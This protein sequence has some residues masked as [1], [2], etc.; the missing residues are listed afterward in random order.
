M[1]YMLKCNANIYNETEESSIKK[2]V[3]K[4]QHGNIWIFQLKINK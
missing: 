4:W 3:E 1:T 2:L